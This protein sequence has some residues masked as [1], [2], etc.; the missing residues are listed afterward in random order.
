M[1]LFLSFVDD[2]L[3]MA[4]SCVVQRIAENA[5]LVAKCAGSRICF[6]DTSELI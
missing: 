2:G 5:T 3:E 1:L 4:R 6:Y